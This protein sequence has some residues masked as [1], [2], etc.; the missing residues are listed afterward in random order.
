VEQRVTGL[1]LVCTGN[2]CRSP[3]AE[4]LLT[5]ALAHD[6]DLRVSSAG[7]RALVDQP[8]DP[9]MAEL[10]SAA[11]A[12]PEGF[13]ARLLT[14]DLLRRAD[15]VLVMAREH[16]SAVVALEP[17]AVRRTFLL[18]EIADVAERVAAA[19]WPSGLRGAAARLAALPKLAPAFRAE[20]QFRGADFDVPDPYRRSRREYAEAMGLVAGA[21]RSLA[22]SVGSRGGSE[23]VEDPIG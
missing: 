6:K 12:R 7:T 20:M 10:L 19:G 13:R 22:A 15:V 3:A 23:P 2:V 5:Q 8:M 17:T 11:G 18:L 14:A 9:T 16:R 4:R 21:V 1:L